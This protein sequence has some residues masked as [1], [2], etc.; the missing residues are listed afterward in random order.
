[1]LVH[2]INS[3]FITVSEPSRASLL[4]L[5]DSK[6]KGVLMATQRTSSTQRTRVAGYL[7][8]GTSPT[9]PRSSINVLTGVNGL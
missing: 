8:A 1:M 7:T 5:S 3:A 4:F 6:R 9:G 2:R